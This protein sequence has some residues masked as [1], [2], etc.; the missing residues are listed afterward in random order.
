[1]LLRMEKF[2]IEQLEKK[3]FSPALHSGDARFLLQEYRSALRG[4]R[5]PAHVWLQACEE[6]VAQNLQNENVVCQCNGN[7]CDQCENKRYILA[8]LEDM[9]QYEASINA[10]LKETLLKDKLLFPDDYPFYRRVLVMI[11]DE[12]DN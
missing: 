1:M 7:D 9:K 4:R 10:C 11:D 8:M 3:T 5:F 2:Y 12:K 6:R